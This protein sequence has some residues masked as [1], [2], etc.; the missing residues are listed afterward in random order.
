M[1]F[2]EWIN[3]DNAHYLFEM[4]RVNQKKKN[5]YDE[6]DIKLLNSEKKKYYNEYLSDR[7]GL[8]FIFVGIAGFAFIYW[9]LFWCCFKLPICCYLPEKDEKILKVLYLILIYVFYSFNFVLLILSFIYS[10]KY[11]KR[12]NGIKCAL[13][14]N[15]YNIKEGQILKNK[16]IWPGLDNLYIYI[17]EL[18]KFTNIISEYKIYND[19]GL[20]YFDYYDIIYDENEQIYSLLTEFNKA[21][22]NLLNYI[23]GDESKITVKNYKITPNYLTNYRDIIDNVKE[24][25]YD[26]TYDIIKKFNDF[27]IALNKIKIILYS[28]TSLYFEDEYF[29]QYDL[30]NSVKNIKLISDSFEEYKDKVLNTFFKIQK[31]LKLF[32]VKLNLI[33]NIIYMILITG[34]IVFLSLYIFVNQ[35]KLFRIILMIL[36]NICMAFTIYYFLL[37]GFFGM[38]NFGAKDSIG[39]FQ[40]I[41]SKNNLKNDKFIFEEKTLELF[42]E[43]IYGNGNFSNLIYLTNENMDNFND[44]SYISK[45]YFTYYNIINLTSSKDLEYQISNFS[46]ARILLNN[47]LNTKK[48][49]SIFSKKD[50]EYIKN[51]FNSVNEYTKKNPSTNNKYDFWY[52]EDNDCDSNSAIN[53]CKLKDFDKYENNGNNCNILNYKDDNIIN[54]IKLLFKIYSKNRDIINEIIKKQNEIIYSLRDISKKF[55][56][57]N[58]E[59]ILNEF[60]SYF[61]EYFELTKMN[62]KSTNLISYM[63]CNFI[64]NDLNITY[65]ILLD[66]AEQ[67]NSML[68][69]ISLISFFSLFFINFLIMTLIRYNYEDEVEINEKSKIGSYRKNI[70][71]ISSISSDE[72]E[73]NKKN[74]KLRKRKENNEKYNKMKV[75]KKKSNSD[76]EDNDN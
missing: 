65:K 20:N 72:Q 55:F 17:D 5:V 24:E 75:F 45:F 47:A 73:Y 58:R 9:G 12:L 67:D 14:R 32:G 54:T 63:N 33:F 2:T 29:E 36:W 23:D 68:I 70:N 15:Y 27:Q 31:Y 71:S 48:F 40:T 37:T 66:F 19:F 51:L 60:S 30:K 18:S 35:K 62:E 10:Y 7:L 74:F 4:A 8:Y 1:N 57:Y 28:D 64:R 61:Y 59:S 42:N 38:V 3:K 26:D 52:I 39:L 69:I 21:L 16:T 34:I 49:Y 46:S 6:Y 56:I 41:F 13:E 25:V 43:C 22:D 50:E 53:C 11:N 44:F 76:D